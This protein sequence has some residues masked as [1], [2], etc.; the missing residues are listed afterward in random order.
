MR[1][2]ARQLGKAPVAPVGREGATT[3]ASSSHSMADDEADPRMDDDECLVAD[4]SFSTRFSATRLRQI[5]DR[6]PKKK[7]DVICLCSFGS[8][9]NINSFSVP[10]NLLDWVVMKID[11]EKSLFSHRQKS[12]LFTKDMVRKIFN[13]TSGSRAVELLRRNEPH[14]LREP[15]RVG[16][17]APTRRTIEVLEVADVLDVVTIKTAWVLLCIALV[18]SPGTGNMVPLEYLASLVDMDSINEFAWD[19][20]FLA[21]AL[22]EV[23]KYQKK[24]NEGKT[25]FWIGGCLPMFAIIYMD[26]VEVPRLLACEHRIDYS[27]PRSCFVCNDDFKLIQEIDRNK[28]SLDKID[29]GKRNL[30]AHYPFFFIFPILFFFAQHQNNKFVRTDAPTHDIPSNPAFDG[31]EVGGDVCGSLDEW[32]HPLP[33]SEEMEIPRHMIP[34]YEKHKKLHATEVKKVLKSFGQVLEGMFCKRLASILAEANANATSINHHHHKPGDVTFHAPAGN[35]ADAGHTRAPIHTSPE[36][37]KSPAPQEVDADKEVAGCSN[38]KQNEAYKEVVG[39]SN[40]KQNEADKKVAGC[41]NTKQNEAQRDIGLEKMQSCCFPGTE[42]VQQGP[43]LGEHEKSVGAEVGGGGVLKDPDVA[44]E[45][46]KEENNL[47]P[48]NAQRMKKIKIEPKDD[49]LYQQYILSRYKIPKTKHGKPIPDFI[50]IEGFHTSLE[51]FHASLKPQAEID[52]DIMTLYLKTFNLEQMYNRKK[53]KKLAVSVFMGVS[54]SHIF[55]FIVVVQNRHWDV[56]VANLRHKQFN[57]F[58]SIKNSEDVTLLTNATNNVI[59]NIKKVANCESAFKFDLNSF[60]LVTPDY[61]AQGTHYNCGFYAILYLENYN[62]VVMMH[63][64][65]SYIPNLRKRIAANLLKHPSNNLDPAEQLRK[66]LED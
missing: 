28:L 8:L 42:D 46:S 25:A 49:A 26:F 17:R 56:V 21:V 16:S 38:T 3:R 27:L 4:G 14:V 53:P 24:R 59:T 44:D 61:L 13:V 58:D 33:S 15:Y 7:K 66:L 63:F 51:N 47:A 39:C 36:A 11:P 52:S 34:I 30:R 9:L 64:D 65:E 6:L 62:S 35:A 31:C 29:F 22:N 2:L 19:E 1:R 40:T 5:A 18:L 48:V 54:V 45:G 55:R 50:E 57:V 60:E 23:K 20:H 41:S 32:L 37:H 12:I 43:V 10:T